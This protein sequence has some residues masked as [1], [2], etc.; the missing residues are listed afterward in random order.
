MHFYGLGAPESSINPLRSRSRRATRCRHRALSSRAWLSLQY[1]KI[2]DSKGSKNPARG[3]FVVVAP[4][5]G[6]PEMDLKAMEKGESLDDGGY[7]L[8]VHP[9]GSEHRVS[10]TLSRKLCAR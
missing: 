5:L 1:V 10:I 9:I 4:I 8:V 6:D 2:N 7:H 3:E